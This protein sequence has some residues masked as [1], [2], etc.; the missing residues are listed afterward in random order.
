MSRRGYEKKR[1][2]PGKSKGK[3]ATAARGKDNVVGA[4][5]VL[6][7]LDPRAETRASK[8]ASERA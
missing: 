7:S 6:S 1:E 2:S 8:R 3:P 5:L 4:S